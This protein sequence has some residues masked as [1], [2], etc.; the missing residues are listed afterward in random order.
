M[1][2]ELDWKT[3]LRKVS[4]IGHWRAVL[5]ALAGTAVATYGWNTFYPHSHGFEKLWMGL[6]TGGTV[7]MIPGTIWQL[8]NRERRPSTSGWFLATSILSWGA[9]AAVAVFLMAPDLSA[10]EHERSVLRALDVENI[11]AVSVHVRGH[12]ARRIKEHEVLALFVENTKHAELFYPSHELCTTEFKIV[13]YR[14]NGEESGYD[15]CI[16][17]R[18]PSDFSLSYRAYFSVRDVLVPGAQAWLERYGSAN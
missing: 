10:E 17:E 3:S 4:V 14:K 2:R 9:F 12:D 13:I 1:L 6:A 8:W 5:C 11:S 15:G 16:P 7:G 18:H